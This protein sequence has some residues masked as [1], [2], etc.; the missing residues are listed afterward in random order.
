MRWLEKTVFFR[1][2]NY[3][4]ISHTYAIWYNLVYPL[5]TSSVISFLIFQF[6]CARDLFARDSLLSAFIPFLSVLSPFYI[7][8]LAAIA[9][10]SASDLLD[11]PFMMSK[12]VTLDIIGKGGEWETIDVTPR[13]FLSL[14]FG[15]CTT[16]SLFI[17]CI[18]IFAPF[19]GQGISHLGLKI[20]PMILSSVVFAYLFLLAQL[21][22]N[23]ILGVYYLADRLHR[24]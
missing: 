23:T 13:H 15:Y 5:I 20:T 21:L 3:L 19:I 4:R 17:L 1:S 2:L 6:S 18:S 24:V 7:A 12:P 9:T 11:R 14:M 22:V 16:L 10:F 8:A